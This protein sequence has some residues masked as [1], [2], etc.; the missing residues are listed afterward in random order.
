MGYA[1]I[2]FEPFEEPRRRIVSKYEGQGFKEVNQEFL[3]EGFHSGHPEGSDLVDQN[4][5]V[6]IDNKAG[7]AV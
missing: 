1:P 2:L 5:P 6:T 3:Y 7:Q 4:I